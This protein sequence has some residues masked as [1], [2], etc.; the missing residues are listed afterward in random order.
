MH[1]VPTKSRLLFQAVRFTPV[2]AWVECKV[3][4]E[5]GLD[6]VFASTEAF[7]ATDIANDE[8]VHGVVGSWS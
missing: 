1:S 2:I 7:Q 5:P 8:G 4:F 6:V 3:K